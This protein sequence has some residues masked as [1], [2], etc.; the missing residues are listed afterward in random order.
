MY[1]I[2]NIR[3]IQVNQNNIRLTYCQTKFLS[4]WHSY[5]YYYPSWGCEWLLIFAFVVK[6]AFSKTICLT[7][8]P[9]VA[10]SLQVLV[11]WSWLFCWFFFHFFYHNMLLPY[12]ISLCLSCISL[13]ADWI[14][15]LKW[16]KSFFS[17]MTGPKVH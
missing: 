7:V 3:L 1:K 12:L 14:N 10:L 16:L 9:K 6:H 5:R 17:S 11:T 15:I 13:I 8:F 2:N 4:R